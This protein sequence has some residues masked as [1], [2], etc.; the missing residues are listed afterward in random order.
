MV[1]EKLTTRTVPTP[2]GPVTYRLERKAVK[3]LNLRVRRDGSVCLSAGRRV[4][5]SQIDA[6]VVQKAAFIHRAIRQFR[7]LEERQ[8]APRAYVTG[9]RFFLLGRQ[10]R[11]E[12][13]RGAPEGAAVEGELLRLRLRDPE[14]AARRQR[15]V[16]KFLDESC[17][18]VFRQ[19]LEEVY[20]PFRALGVE[21]PTLRLRQMKSR[22]GSCLV[23]KKVVT[24]NKRLLAAPRPC[25]QYVAVHELCHFLH[26]DH[27]QRFY[28]LLGAMMPDWKARREALNRGGWEKL[29]ADPPQDVG[30]GADQDDGDAGGG[31][32][33]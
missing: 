12:V 30:D 1:Q 33:L 32:V 14:D 18:E 22:W 4:P 7:E 11:L 29:Q 13:S 25:I 26:P 19:V 10:L 23:Q 5:V 9:E 20:P 3:N 24:L 16:E 15:L 17:R 2:E 31:Q 28:R 8:P 6:F 21:M 27:S